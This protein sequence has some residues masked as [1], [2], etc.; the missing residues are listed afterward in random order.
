MKTPRHEKKEQ[1]SLNS[2]GFLPYLGK[3][4]RPLDTK[5][6]VLPTTPATRRGSPTHETAFPRASAQSPPRVTLAANRPTITYA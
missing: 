5:S 4:Y 1:F 6:R 3:L 2:S